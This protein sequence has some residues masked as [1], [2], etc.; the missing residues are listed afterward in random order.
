MIE[1][2]DKKLIKNEKE[3]NAI[4]RIKLSSILV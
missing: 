2:D 3:M 1:L 4:L